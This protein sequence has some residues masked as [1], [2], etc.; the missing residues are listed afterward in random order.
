[1]SFREWVTRVLAIAFIL[2]AIC[3]ALLHGPK[4]EIA[5]KTVYPQK[6]TWSQFPQVQ[7]P[8]WRQQLHQEET[9]LQYTANHNHLLTAYKPRY[10]ISWADPS[11][12]GERY[13]KDFNGIPVHN[14]PIVVLHETTYSAESALNFFQARHT[15]DQV[16]ASYHSL[17]KLDGTIVYIVPPDK[18]AFGAGDSVFAGPDGNETVQ[19]NPKLPPS[20]NNFAY[21]ISLETPPDGWG[22]KE[23]KHS[24]YTE[25][26]YNSLAWL[27]AQCSVP[28]ERITTH[29]FVDR[30][31]QRIDPTNFDGNK[32]FNLLHSY[33]ELL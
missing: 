18:R 32:F 29:R 14:Q 30:S 9:S 5:M 22:D 21:H 19:T 4:Q 25:A 15:D 23:V 8:S 7:V 24:P 33:R 10:E 1:M 26:Q 31:G 17:I 28:D 13:N 20:V 27:V 12:Y 2:A 6:T 11:N 16:E 3:I